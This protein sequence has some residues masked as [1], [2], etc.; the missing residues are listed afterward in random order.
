MYGAQLGAVLWG[1]NEMRKSNESRA[2]QIE[3]LG[4]ALKDIGVGLREQS[5][6]LRAL[7]ERGT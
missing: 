5:A 2:G 4:N 7:L 1:I 3:I 6:G